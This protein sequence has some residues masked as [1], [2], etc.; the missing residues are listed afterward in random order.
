[1][2]VAITRTEYDAAG[3]RRLASHEADAKASRRLWVLASVLGGSSR[4]GAARATGM[5][6]K[7]L[8]DWAHRYN[9]SG[10]PRLSNELRGGDPVAKLNP[11]EKERLAEWVR[12]G[13]NL[14]ED[15]VVRWRLSD[16]KRRVLDRFFATVDERSIGR[17]L[18][19][20]NFGNISVRPRHPKVNRE[21]QEARKKTSRPL[22]RVS[23]WPRREIGRSNSGE[24]IKLGS[25]NRAA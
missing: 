24:R 1:M 11:A 20:M 14:E 19:A 15:R 21:A 18:K 16:L 7:S 25:A 6:R 17:M 22:L 13:P 4:V 8:R 3:L 9:G 5:D 23:S 2:T 12:Q 10:V